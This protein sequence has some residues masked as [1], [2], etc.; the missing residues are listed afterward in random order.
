MLLHVQMYIFF[1]KQLYNVLGI[2]FPTF[3]E[4]TF[5]NY[6]TLNKWNPNKFIVRVEI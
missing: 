4:T 1:I 5:I 2:N 3:L 6:F